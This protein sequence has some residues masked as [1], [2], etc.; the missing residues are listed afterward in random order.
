MSQ[1]KPILV[2]VLMSV[3]VTASAQRQQILCNKAQY[4]LVKLI[5]FENQPSA[6]I[7]GLFRQHVRHE[8]EMACR[9]SEEPS[10]AI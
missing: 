8:A 7:C 6:T 4:R 2:F 9:L 1:V 5:E 10:Q 3:M